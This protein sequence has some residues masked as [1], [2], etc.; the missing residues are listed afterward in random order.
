MSSH[1][2]PGDRKAI[3]QAAIDERRSS[4]SFSR[5]DEHPCIL[6]ANASDSHLLCLYIPI[7]ER[8]ALDELTNQLAVEMVNQNM[9]RST[10]VD[11]RTHGA[12]ADGN[13]ERLDTPPKVHDWASDA[14]DDEV[15]GRPMRKKL[16]TIPPVTPHT[17]T[18]P[19]HIPSAFES[20]DGKQLWVVVHSCNMACSPLAQQMWSVK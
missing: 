20:N 5:A 3:I 19:D 18:K 10:G 16:K 1:P 7:I 12:N 4:P 15:N 6:L 9:I 13:G 11:S 17:Y 8:R 2:I 14:D